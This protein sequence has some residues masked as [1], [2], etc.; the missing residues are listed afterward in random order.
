[1]VTSCQTSL[2]GL[3]VAAR[4]PANLSKPSPNIQG[5]DNELPAESGKGV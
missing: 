1:M 4:K 5:P 2:E 3:K